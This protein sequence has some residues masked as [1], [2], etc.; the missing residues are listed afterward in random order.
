MEKS[1]MFMGAFAVLLALNFGIAL[2]FHFNFFDISIPVGLL[3]ILL[4]APN[5]PLTDFFNTE[6]YFY[7]EEPERG[8]KFGRMAAISAITYCLLAFVTTFF[9]YKDYF[10][11]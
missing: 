3:G 11:N 7:S 2:Y 4:T 9:Y 8:P 6:P 5:N 1:I 10:I